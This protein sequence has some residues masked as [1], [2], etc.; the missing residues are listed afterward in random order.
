MLQR[1]FNFATNRIEIQNF[2]MLDKNG[3]EY[4]P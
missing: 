1:L 3:Q 2:T 4:T